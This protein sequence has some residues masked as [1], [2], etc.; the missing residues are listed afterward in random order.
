MGGHLQ[1]GPISPTTN[2]AI[3][4]KVRPTSQTPE[5]QVVPTSPTPFNIRT[6]WMSHKDYAARHHGFSLPP[7][8]SRTGEKRSHLC[9]KN[10]A[11]PPAFSGQSIPTWILVLTTR[12]TITRTTSFHYNA[13]SQ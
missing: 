12:I 9:C 4:P 3:R 5:P 10:A 8:D 6:L 13:A 2:P 11:E 1:V 7:A